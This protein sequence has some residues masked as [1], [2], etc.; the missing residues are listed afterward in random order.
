[1][2]ASFS[3]NVPSFRPM[4]LAI[5]GVLSISPSAASDVLGAAST[6]NSPRARISMPLRP[7]SSTLILCGLPSRSPASGSNPRR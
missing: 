1:M 6:A 4:P 5:V 2:L 3:V 7:G